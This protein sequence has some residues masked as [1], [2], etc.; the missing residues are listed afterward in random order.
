MEGLLALDGAHTLTAY[1]RAQVV[2]WLARWDVTLTEW[3]E[4]HELRP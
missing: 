3:S 1:S 4:E 2:K